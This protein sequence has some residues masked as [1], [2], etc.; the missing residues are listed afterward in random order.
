V[1]VSTSKE[2]RRIAAMFD[3]IAWRYDTLKH[4]VSLGLD[5]YWRRLGVRTLRLTGSEHVLDMCT[6]TGDLA[7]GLVRGRGGNARAVIGVDFAEAMLGHAKAKIDRASLTSRIA[8]VRGD[9]TA[10]PFPDATFDAATVA[11]GIRNVVD[12]RR[13]CEELLRVLKPGG[14][15]MVLE[16]GRPRIPGIRTLYDW[17]FRYLLPRVGRA[18][19]KDD[20]AYS[21]LPASVR[22]FP[23]GP[24]FTRVLQ[25]AGFPE[26]RDVSLTFGIVYMY[27][28]RRGA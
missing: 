5:R 22:T 11:F 16:F 1:S 14:R 19:S 8:L 17:Y 9:A 4:L 26:A 2:P 10:I 12:T 28:A 7:M 18:M 6:G 20:D 27:V 25:D 15:L 23:D 3:R 24:D 13:G 21:Y